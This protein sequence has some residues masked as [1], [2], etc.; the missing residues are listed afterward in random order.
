M[1]GLEGIAFREA[2]ADDWPAIGLLTGRNPEQAAAL[3]R[4]IQRDYDPWLALV[5][6][7]ATPDSAAQRIVGAVVAGALRDRG[8]GPS[9]GAG[10]DA[11]RVAR[12][13][14]IEV[15]PSFRRR[16]IGRRLLELALDDLRA[17][18]LSRAALLVDAGQF[19]ALA[20]FRATGF[21]TETESIALVLPPLAAAAIAGV[22]PSPEARA[23]V[24]PLALDDVP[25]AAGLL[26]ELG[27]ERA[28]APHDTLPALTP[29]AL[30]DWLQRRETLAYA[31][32]ES[33]D[34]QTPLG[35]A[36]AGRRRDDA[37]LYFV[38]VQDEVRRRGIGRALVGAL[39]EAAARSPAAAEPAAGASARFRPLR[40]QVLDPAELLPFFRALG[41][42]SEG[43]TFEQVKAL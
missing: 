15:L 10:A 29:D 42:E 41:F 2:E 37:S 23:I 43:V 36:W 8:S 14:W 18:Q 32:W 11:Q 17:R 5:A 24:R 21:A 34:P 31:A 33:R 16:G 27:V 35:I 3:R 20:L 38:G 7:A 22:A 30:S 6:V 40:A 19:E 4:Q 13:L 28:Q 39:A 25:H 9:A 12:L 26:I 1:A